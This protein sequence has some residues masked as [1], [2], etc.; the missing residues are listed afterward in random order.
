MPFDLEG[1]RKAGYS[2]S[3]IAEHLAPQFN[4][5][6]GAARNAGYSDTDIVGEIYTRSN[7][8][9]FMRGAEVAVKQT[10]ALFKG[11]IGLVGAT[12]E[13]VVGEG[14]VATAVK[15]W[16]LRGYQEGMQ[17]LQPLQNEN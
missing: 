1:A 15:D 3:E 4:F 13:R 2:D 9:D 12:S 5:D 10:P 7:R 8:G 14:G 17:K 6:L 16:V 11:L